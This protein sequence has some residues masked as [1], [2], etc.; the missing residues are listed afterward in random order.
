[1]CEPTTIFLVVSAASAAVGAYSAIQTGRAQQASAEFNA[2]VQQRNAQAA[3]DEQANV[4]DEAAIERRRRG[5]RVRAERGDLVAKYSAMGVDP[6][7]GTPADLIGDTQRA[8]NID[9]SI[10]G[11][12]EE[13]AIKNLDK[14]IA[15]YRD[16]ATLSRMEGKSAV[17]AGNTAAV[18]SILQGAANV[19]SKWIQP[20]T[21]S[22]APGGTSIA[23]PRAQSIFAPLPTV[24]PLPVGG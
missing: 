10:L 4:R 19:S 3:E 17:R 1:M 11:R 24:K 16:A 15:D 9:L 8:Y 5:E 13:T 12:N 14:Q 18:G 23:K 22:A 6:G 21:G 7:F 2:Q 20:N